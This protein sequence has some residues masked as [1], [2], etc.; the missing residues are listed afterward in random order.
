VENVEMPMVYS[1]GRIDRGKAMAA[2]ERV[3]LGHRA[4]HFATELSGGEQQRVAIARALIND[5]ALLL[6]DEPTGNLDSAAGQSIMTLLTHLHREGRTIVL[7]THDEQV[8]SH[9]ARELVLRD[10]ALAS[11]RALAGTTR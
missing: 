1:A 2:L 11:D 8:A 7:V 3:G 4:D 10:G 6:A 5:P 9:A